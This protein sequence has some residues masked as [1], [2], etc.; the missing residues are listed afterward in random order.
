LAAA[1][2]AH[3]EHDCLQQPTCLPEGASGQYF[4]SVDVS[5]AA[6]AWAVDRDW[7][8]PDPFASLFHTAEAADPAQYVADQIGDQLVAADGPGTT[9]RDAAAAALI[10]LVERRIAAVLE[11]TSNVRPGLLLSGG[12]DSLLVAACAHRIGLDPLAVTVLYDDGH[13]NTALPL[14][15]SRA[16][17][18][19]KALGIEHRVISMTAA[20][21]HALARRCIRVLETTELWEV[22]AAVPGLAAIEHL[23]AAGACGPALTG[24]GADALFLGGEQL[25]APVGSEKALAEYRSRVTAKVRRNF[26]RAR[27]VPD[28]YERLLGDRADRYVQVFQSE[29]FWRFSQIIDP[30]L[31][32]RTVPGVAGHP[33]QVDKYLLRYAAQK[34]G[35]PGELAFTRKSPLQ[36]SAGIVS[37][38]VTNARK[39]LDGNPANRLYADPKTEPAEH[40][41]ARLYLEKLAR[42]QSLSR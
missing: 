37:A 27:L 7:A 23:D 16:I 21:V 42:A 14:E 13:D 40:T 10:G 38:L 3:A 30:S 28:F 1:A 19:A 22:C 35:L 36:V 17:T 15:D 26:T 34:L 20:D 18:A 29:S 24:S 41:A 4:A 5:N 39:D 9:D 12:I 6:Q 8:P 33:V 31:L 11:T 2:V 32:W 25:T